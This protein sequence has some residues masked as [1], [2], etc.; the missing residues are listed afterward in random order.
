VRIACDAIL[1]SASPHAFMGITKMGMAAIFET[2][3]NPDT[4]LILRGGKEPNYSAD[5]VQEACV[6]LEKSG[7]R[8]QVMIDLSHANSQ[9][10]HQKQIEVAENVAQQIRT[11]E[12]RIT[13]VMIE[14]HLQEGRQDIRSGVVPAK[15]VSLTDAC[16]SWSQ[17]LPVLEN[18]SEAV[19]A[20]R[21]LALPT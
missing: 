12:T 18:L 10:Q 19:R 6:A 13:G 3:G 5:H 11:G 2:R 15:G 9:K 17:T 14:S 7:L 8:P 16:I 21:R 4:H 1:A 20:R